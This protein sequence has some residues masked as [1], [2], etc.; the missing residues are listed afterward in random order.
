V[1]IELQEATTDVQLNLLAENKLD[2]GILIPPLPDKLK[3]ELSYLPIFSEPLMLAI[4]EG[5]ALSR[6]K[7]KIPL[8]SMCRTATDYFSSSDSACIS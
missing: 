4:T 3:V 6:H 5:S 1:H 7:G 2:L 8:T